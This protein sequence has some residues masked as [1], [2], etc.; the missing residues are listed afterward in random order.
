MYPEWRQEEKKR[1]GLT[2]SV[3]G[4][5]LATQHGSLGVMPTGDRKRTTG[6][7]RPRTFDV[8]WQVSWLAGRRLGPVFPGS[9]P[10]TFA[11]RGLAAYSCGGSAGIALP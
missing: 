1:H 7:P 9:L 6:T 3:G 10:V 8:S 5:A 2:P 4:K 11:G